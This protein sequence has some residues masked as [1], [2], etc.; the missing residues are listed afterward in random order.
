MIQH[1]FCPF[2]I[3]S[4]WNID[5]DISEIHRI[6]DDPMSL[7]HWWAPVFMR[8]ELIS[9]GDDNK[10]GLTARFHTKGILPHT[11]QF[12]A[13]IDHMDEGCEMRI[14]TW[15]DFDGLGNIRL[16]HHNGGVSVRI[17]WQTRVHQPYIRGLIRLFKPIFSANHRWAMRR[18]REGLQAEV[19][20]RRHAEGTARAAIAKPAFPHNLQLV[21]RRFSWTRDS[22][23]WPT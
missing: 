12:T 23:R 5:A 17:R 21:Q 6:L 3:E 22:A 10:V 8:G 1:G 15:G 4:D 14:R 16:E 18:G 7:T 2:D 13:R 19:L 11:F 9:A 20:R